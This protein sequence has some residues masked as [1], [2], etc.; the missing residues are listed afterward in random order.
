MEGASSCWPPPSW[1]GTQRTSAKMRKCT[2]AP[3]TRS[4]E[5]DDIGALVI[6]NTSFWSS[7]FN[8]STIS[9]KNP[10]LI[11]QAPFHICSSEL[12]LEAS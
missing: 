9:R 6:T 12:H 11:I 5:E 2:A 10:I 8:Y 4:G 7:L 1:R 3:S